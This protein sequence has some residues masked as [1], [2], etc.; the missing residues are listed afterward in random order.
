MESRRGQE[1]PTA[2]FCCND[3]CAVGCLEGLASS[4]I[5]VPGDVSV[6][7]FDD[8]LASRTS[9][10]QLATV[11]QPLVEMAGLAVELLLHPEM[12]KDPEVPLLLPTKVIT[13]QSISAPPATPVRVP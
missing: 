1:L 7:G 11:K 12:R 8:T 3:G 6:A 10:P 9:V 13:R 5:R 2:I 4:G